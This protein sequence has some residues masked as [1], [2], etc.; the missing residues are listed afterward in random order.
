[1]QLPLGVQAEAEEFAKSESWPSD[2]LEEVA[3][4]VRH[5]CVCVCVCVNRG[6]W[7]TSVTPFPLQ[8]GGKVY[9]WE[10]SRTCLVHLCALN[11]RG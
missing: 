9:C 10:V 4:K 5:V 7:S 1:M 2:N 11:A 6:K 3:L 8:A